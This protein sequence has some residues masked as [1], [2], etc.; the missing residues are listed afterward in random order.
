P[1]GLS[2]NI[3]RPLEP[4]LTRVSF[5]A[6]VWDRSKIGSGAGA[7]LDLVERE[8]EAVVEQ[9][10]VGVRSRFYKH[11]R[12]SPKQEQGVHHFHRLLAEFLAV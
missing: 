1:W 3:V 7:E 8:D 6:Y 5:R 2:V 12:F 11:G 10:Q 9:V 4:G